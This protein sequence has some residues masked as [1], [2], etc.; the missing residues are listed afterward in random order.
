MHEF[1][2]CEAIVEAVERRADG[3]R[4]AA[5]RVRV[6]ARHVVVS[7]AMDQAFSLASGGTVADGA[8]MEVVVVPMVVACKGCGHTADSADPLA[9]CA[10]CGGVDVDVS[11]GDEL[12]LE[13]V[14]YEAVPAPPSRPA[15]HGE[16]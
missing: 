15:A 13:A 9:V 4:V 8:R 10:A 14:E 6:G 12:V 5:V 3:R 1:G 11:G 16:R 7:S 2:L